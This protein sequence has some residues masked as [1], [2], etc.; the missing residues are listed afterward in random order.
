MVCAV[1]ACV[2]GENRVVDGLLD[3]W[4]SVLSV[5]TVSLLA[6][7]TEDVPCCCIAGACAEGAI[8]VRIDAEG[9]T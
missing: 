8:E 6:M 7:G 9:A 2:A 4:D 5:G 3:G 1:V